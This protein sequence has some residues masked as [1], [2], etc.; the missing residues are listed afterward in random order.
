MKLISIIFL[1]LSSYPAFS[2]FSAGTLI[3]TH[4]GFISIEDLY[5]GDYVQC[6]FAGHHNKVLLKQRKR[7]TGAL[8]ITFKKTN[9]G[10]IVSPE[11]KFYVPQESLW[12]QAQDLQIGDFLLKQDG[13]QL[14]IID[15]YR[16]DQKLEFYDLTIEQCHTFF[17]SDDAVLVHNAFPIVIGIACMFGGGIEFAGI[18]LGITALG[19]FIGL[20]LNKN[21]NNH[22]FEIRTD[23]NSLSNS[24]M[25]NNS[26]CQC[27]CNCFDQACGCTC[28]CSCKK[29]EQRIF[30]KVTKQEFFKGDVIKKNYEHY[31]NGIYRLKTHGEA[32]VKGAYYLCWDHLHNDVEVYNK[33]EIHIGSLDP[34]KLIL[35]KP[36]V[37]GRIFPL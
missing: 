11:Q 4:S 5:I 12:K 35:Y 27:G 16:I 10:I 3:K 2:S 6:C 33:S 8:C 37:L 13:E 32:V 25:N 20:H 30:N 15:I 23:N 7:I 36:A 14:R 29:E 19:A 24:G 18:A 21:K 22:I 1:L 9:T 28:G 34:H 26:P 31:R 17:V